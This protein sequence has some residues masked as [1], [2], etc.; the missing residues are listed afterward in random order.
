MIRVNLLLAKVNKCLGM[1]A[2]LCY[3]AT[4]VS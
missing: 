2:F 3:V 1:P 4:Q